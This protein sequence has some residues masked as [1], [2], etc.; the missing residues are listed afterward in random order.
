MAQVLKGLRR[1]ERN[2]AA[3]RPPQAPQP[4]GP[5]PAATRGQRRVPPP[6]RPSETEADLVRHALIGFA[7]ESG[8]ATAHDAATVVRTSRSLARRVPVSR[9]PGADLLLRSARRQADQLETRGR[10]EVERYAAVGRAEETRAAAVADTTF[11][12]VAATSIDE[13]TELSVTRLVESDRVHELLLN[14]SSTLLEDLVDTVRAYADRWNDRAE[15]WARR[16]F[17]RGRPRPPLVVPVT[18]SFVV[19]TVVIARREHP[20]G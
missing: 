3:P 10:R 8:R 14:Q 9:V 1:L 6:P 2:V 4:P 11:Q 19:P 7:A 16:V 20:D 18:R 17:R 12:Q 13:I 5:P 15:I